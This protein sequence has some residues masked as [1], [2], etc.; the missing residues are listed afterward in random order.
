MRVFRHRCCRLQVKM[1]Q[2]PRETE[3]RDSKTLQ[4]LTQTL[5]EAKRDL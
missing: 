5:D 3:K 2:S 4:Q 1:N